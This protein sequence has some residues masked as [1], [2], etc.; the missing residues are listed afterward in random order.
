[1]EKGNSG[2]GIS[3]IEAKKVTKVYGEPPSQIVA[4]NDVSITIPKGA[5]VCIVGQSGCGKTTL[6]RIFAGLEKPTDGKVMLNNAEIDGPGKDRAMV[7]QE[8][9]LFPWK[10]VQQNVEFGLKLAGVDKSD[11]VRIAKRY[12]RL[13]G[14]HGF[15]DNYPAELSGGMRQRV[16]IATSLAVNPEVLLMDEPFGACDAQTRRRLQKEILRI[17]KETGKTFIMVT[18]SV[19]EAVFLGSRI[20]VLSSR[21]G[22]VRKV[23]E[24]DIPYPRARN[25]DRFYGAVNEIME[26]LLGDEATASDCR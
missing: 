19:S 23:L 1:M 12:I 18:H 20:Y 26:L 8:Y 7:F 25:D 3:I 17:W 14:V 2:E 15:E 6:L 4:L 22:R 21:P 5:F 9:T 11:R 24:P 16:A 13:V 10:T